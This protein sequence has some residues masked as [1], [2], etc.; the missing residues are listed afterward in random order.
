MGAEDPEHVRKLGEIATECS[1]L[2]D[3]LKQLVF[4]LSEPERTFT[5]LSEKVWR[6]LSQD[7][8]LK[9]T[10][11]RQSAAEAQR[12]ALETE[13][14]QI[15]DQFAER[16]ADIDDAITQLTG[17]LKKAT[18]DLAVQAKLETDISKASINTVQRLR[19]NEHEAIRH[20]SLDI[21]PQSN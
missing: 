10:L 2:V 12:Q 8:Q 9:E 20:G 13:L 6:C 19:L 14:Q 21:D 16:N 1:S 11:Q 4:D 17:E 15:E 3:Q 18:D 5:S 7:R